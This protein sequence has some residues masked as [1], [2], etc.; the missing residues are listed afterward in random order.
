MKFYLNRPRVNDLINSF[1]A[2]Y[3]NMMEKLPK[4]RKKV[5]TCDVCSTTFNSDLQAEAHFRGSRHNKKIKLMEAKGD[6]GSF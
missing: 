6:L 4:K 5:S 3:N 2:V 1:Q